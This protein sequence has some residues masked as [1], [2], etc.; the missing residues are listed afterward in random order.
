MT[1]PMIKAT[2]M[3]TVDSDVPLVL[4]GGSAHAFYA[5][6][7]DLF[8]AESLSWEGAAER[9]ALETGRRPVVVEFA[10]LLAREAI[11]RH[12]AL[13]TVCTTGSELRVLS[14]PHLPEV[15][16]AVGQSNM[17]PLGVFEQA[18]WAI[19]S[20]LPFEARLVDVKDLGGGRHLFRLVL[21]ALTIPVL[22]DVAPAPQ[23]LWADRLF[24]LYLGKGFYGI[25]QS[26]QGPF[27]WM[28]PQGRVLV[29]SSVSRLVKVELWVEPGVARPRKLIFRGTEYAFAGKTKITAY[30]CIIPGD[31][32][33]DLVVLGE[34]DS[35]LERGLSADSRAMALKVV[36]GSVTGL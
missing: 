32:P 15:A 11:S 19:K 14:G 33:F 1:Q 16:L 26:E 23:L 22:E 12:Q 9:P 27:S 24:G 2:V 13:V 21:G 5:G 25:E 20:V 29:R 34:V 17:F 28:G 6:R 18:L 7:A 4:L 35:P 10:E 8:R 36:R 30:G 31:N 3:P